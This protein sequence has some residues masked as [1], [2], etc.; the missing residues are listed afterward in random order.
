MDGFAVAQ[1]INVVEGVGATRGARPGSCL[2]PRTESAGVA[3]AST[4]MQKWEMA[5]IPDFAALFSASPYPYLLIDTGFVIIG[6]N[7]AY[8][9]A[10]G[11]TADDIVGK[12][13]FTAF[14][15]NP[16]DPESTNLDEVRISIEKAIA[17]RAPHTSAL[18]R[19]AVPHVTPA[20]TVFDERY[21]SAVHT[22][23]FDA[24]GAVVFVAQRTGEDD[25]G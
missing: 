17:T 12:H 2:P 8:L 24:T 7:P 13:I 5:N 25:A 21:W 6:A 15:S 20:G 3:C 19:Y 4:C 9:Q 16:A 11:R 23:V 10:T 1:P 14:P 18:L 22:P